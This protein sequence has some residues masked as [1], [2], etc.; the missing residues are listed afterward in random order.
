VDRGKAMLAVDG[1]TRPTAT[2]EMRS[3][4]AAALADTATKA[5]YPS[6]ADDAPSW[7]DAHCEA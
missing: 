2:A 1:S 3:K 5:G 4:A 7:L 6:S